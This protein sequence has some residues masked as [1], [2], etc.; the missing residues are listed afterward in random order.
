MIG[1][2]RS[3]ARDDPCWTR[4]VGPILLTREAENC[5]RQL[6]S[7]LSID[8]FEGVDYAVDEHGHRVYDI[9]RLHDLIDPLLRAM[10][11]EGCRCRMFRGSIT[12][13]VSAYQETYVIPIQVVS[14]TPRII[15]LRGGA[16]HNLLV[17]Y[18]HILHTDVYISREADFLVVGEGPPELEQLERA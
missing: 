7:W 15:N 6:A 13:L 2:F 9:T 11:R 4:M 5:R 3:P 8:R 1:N 18:Y 12:K 10:N 17:G 14:D 16:P